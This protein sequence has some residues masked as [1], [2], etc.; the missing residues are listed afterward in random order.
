S[1]VAPINQVGHMDHLTTSDDYLPYTPNNDTVYSGGIVEL[2]DEPIIM[3][4]PDIADRYWS[5]EFADT[6]MENQFYIGT[7]ATDGKGGIHVFVGPDWTGSRQD[8]PARATIHHLDYNS[9]IFALRISIDP[10]DKYGTPTQAAGTELAHIV[11]DLQPQFN[12]TSL[13]NWKQGNCGN[14]AIADFS[15]TNR[16]CGRAAVPE[17]IKQRPDYDGAFAFYQLMADLMIE[18]PPVADHDAAVVPFK[19]IGLNVGEKFDP[20]ALLAPTQLGVAKAGLASPMIMNWKVKYRGTNYETRWN[21][22]HPGTYNFDYL[23]R[24]A[25]ALE[26]LFV[27]DREEAVYFSTYESRTC[28]VDDDTCGTEKNPD[29]VAFFDSGNKYVMHFEPNEI[30]TTNDLG[31]WSL[32]MYGPDFQLVDN[33]LDRYLLGSRN[34]GLKY[35]GDGSLDIYIQNTSPGEELEGNWLPCPK[36]AG[37]LFRINYRIY[38]PSDAVLDNLAGYI[39][40]VQQVN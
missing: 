30:P 40:P 2:V 3:T 7:R 21:N 38:L 20:K 19:Y 32:T 14:V 6:N 4:V 5:I 13:S 26:G 12:L 15:R 29:K 9:N 23:D 10:D 16:Y 1:P 11:N 18:N 22:L 8:L 35:N 28:E 24:A 31:F 27:H 37:N 34:D 25:G 33:E 17:S 39:P 36:G